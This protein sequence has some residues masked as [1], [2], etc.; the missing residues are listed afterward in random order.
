MIDEQR[1]KIYSDSWINEKDTPTMRDVFI[2]EFE[3]GVRA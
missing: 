3:T 2:S 1:L